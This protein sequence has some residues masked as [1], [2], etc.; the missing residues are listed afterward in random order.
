MA[1]QT[2]TETTFLRPAV[3]PR[4]DFRADTEEV[5]AMQGEALA[6]RWA[7]RVR[8][9][10]RTSFYP[11]AAGD[12]VAHC[13]PPYNSW[14]ALLSAPRLGFDVRLDPDVAAIREG[15][16][17]GSLAPTVH[18]IVRRFK[19]SGE[20]ETASTLR[21]WWL[22]YYVFLYADQ[23]DARLFGC[24]CPLRGTGHVADLE[25]VAVLLDP[26]SLR[27]PWTFYSA[28][29]NTESSWVPSTLDS[30]YSPP[31]VYVALDVQA[32]YPTPGRKDRI[33]FAT[34]DLC[35]SRRDP[36]LSY[37]LEYLDAA[38]PF[39]RFAG[40][41]GPDGIAAPGHGE[42]NRFDLPGSAT[43]HIDTAFARRMFRTS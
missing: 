27:S 16:A 39:R 30:S 42:G 32:N 2:P 10:P 6:R 28:H 36:E 21:G 19:S 23:P 9:H 34:A 22:I 37:A 33:W 8:M 7:P 38:H 5:P 25:W 12:Y 41:L 3:V 13:A 26:T 29:G 40:L 14:D 11:I 4:I 35:A 43:N 31:P 15:H 18:A 24:C 20:G 17:V 1:E